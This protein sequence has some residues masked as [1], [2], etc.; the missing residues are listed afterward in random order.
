[1][2][3]AN[4]KIKSSKE[5]LTSQGGAILFGEFLSRIGFYKSAAIPGGKF[6]GMNKGF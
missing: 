2:N 5:L 4:Y 3:I 6:S 1:M